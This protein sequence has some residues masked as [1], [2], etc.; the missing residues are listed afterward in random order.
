MKLKIKKDDTVKVISGAAA[1]QEAAQ[2]RARR[3]A[4]RAAAERVQRRGLRQ[5]QILARC[6]RPRAR[7]LAGRREQ[8]EE[9]A[10]AAQGAARA[11][12]GCG[13]SAAVAPGPA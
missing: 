1:G 8:A 6:R 11:S 9:Q 3:R 12:N 4:A 5:D 7:A 13:E 2:I 10:T